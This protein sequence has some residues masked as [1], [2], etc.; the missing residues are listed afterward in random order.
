MSKNLLLKK[1]LERRKSKAT[2]LDRLLFGILGIGL[3]MM[4]A[5]F[6]YLVW[7]MFTNR[8]ATYTLPAEKTVA[9]FE[10]EDLTLPPRLNQETVLDLMG[11]STVLEQAFQ[12]DVED[13]QEQLS[14]G[15]LGLALLK[16]GDNKNKLVLFFRVRSQKQAL[17]F[18][19]ELGLEGEKLIVSGDKKLPIYSYSQS[20]HF[21]FSFIGPYLFITEKPSTLEM[22]Q[23]VYRGED[24]NLNADPDYR[25][26]LA[27]LPRQAW[28]YG[29]LNVQAL[30]FGENNALN[31][32]IEPLKSI[33][34]HLVLTIQ[35]E[36]NGFHFNTLLSLDPKLLALKKGYTDSTRF[37]Y[38]LADFLGSQ[39]LAA[40]I[41][42]ANL[43]DEWQ[44]TLETISQLNPAYGIILEGVVRAQVSRVFGEDV[45]LRNDI[46][47]LFSG[48]YALAFDYLENGQLGIRLILKHDDRS[49]AEIKLKKLLEGFQTLA[50][51]F[52]PR[53]KEFTLP[54]GTESREL[55]VDPSRL[56]EIT[57]TYKDYEI[58]CLD[59]SDSAYGFCYAIT[60][61]LIIM[62]NH[63]ESIKETIDLSAS[64][65]FVLSQSQSFRQA[66]S[67]L[68]AVSD[69]I[70]FIELKNLH[71]LLINTPLGVYSQNLLKSFEAVTWIKHYFN[72]GVSTEG[73][74]LLK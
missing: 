53:L 43:S 12:L 9:Y 20:K 73:Y 4:V 13:L 65:R 21:S 40:Y 47:P 16:N 7:F 27:N 39:N 31:Q 64:P 28:G 44:N 59:V 60:D 74:L 37:A 1:L 51:Q 55:V 11:L 26:S 48:E 68:S 14:Q 3:L 15:R 45:S 34:D 36:Y 58:S 41:G 67:N 24:A 66:L 70:T 72:D 42:G 56:K 69:E 30:Y 18:F 22:I 71:P 5:F 33:T 2:F 52:A 54:D 10:L 29:Y 61:E 49:F 32:L 57:E 63:P 6:V 8:S 19:E 46:Y 50:S 17:A 23:A 25:K 38:S 35:K 62:S